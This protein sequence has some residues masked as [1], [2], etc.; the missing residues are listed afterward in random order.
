MEGIETVGITTNGFR[1]N[2]MMTPLIDAG[3]NRIN[4]SLDTL[5]RERFRQ[6]TGV[7]GFERVL[8]AIDEA[9]QS[10]AFEFVKINTVIMRG[11]N[12]TEIPSLVGWAL[13]RH[14]DLR[15][16][17]YMPVDGAGKHAALFMSEEEI[18]SRMETSLQST[19]FHDQYR[20][21][22]E[23]FCHENYP[24]RIS[25]ISAVSR[26]FCDG[27]NRLRLSSRGELLGCLF[28]NENID[29]AAFLEQ[30]FS[31]DE[32]AEMIVQAVNTPEFRRT[33]GE[34]SVADTRPFMRGIGG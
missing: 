23:S 3:L 5:N 9:E 1:M 2:N 31:D 21:P 18:K 33:P 7:D 28:Q 26:C 25:F 17:E 30:G 19:I 22:S 32:I 13:P 8:A 10:G 27:C 14:I 29:L 16:I 20:G 11:I 34:V 15:F 24:G 4:I 6:I 12:D